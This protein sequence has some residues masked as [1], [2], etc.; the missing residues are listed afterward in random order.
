MKGLIRNRFFILTSAF[1]VSSQLMLSAEELDLHYQ[2]LPAFEIGHEAQLVLGEANVEQ[3][4][5]MLSSEDDIEES[6]DEVSAKAPPTYYRNQQK[7]IEQE[8]AILKKEE[9][10]SKGRV[11]PP[12][13]DNAMPCPQDVADAGY[14]VTFDNVPLKEYLNFLSKLTNSNFVYNE[15]DI[16]FNVSVIADS[17]TDLKDV[18]SALMQMLRVNGLSLMEQGNNVIISKDQG[19]RGIASVVSKELDNICT[20]NE[21]LITRVFQLKNINAS[22]VATIISSMVSS[23]ALVE[24]SDDTHHLVVTDVSTNI[25]KVADLLMSLD[26]PEATYEIGIFQVDQSDINNIVSLA[27]KILQPIAD[28]NQLVIV[29]QSSSNNVYIVSTPYLVEKTMEV[30]KSLDKGGHFDEYQQEGF[31]ANARF[32]IYKLQHHKGYQIQQTL[33]ELGADLSGAGSFDEQLVSTINSAQWL[34]ST[35]SLLF[36]GDPKSLRKIKDL[37]E[38]LDAP[39]RQVFIEVLALR[40]TMNNSLNLGVEYGYRARARN[41]LTAVGSLFTSPNP[42]A[43]GNA[44][45]PL[46]FSEGLDRVVGNN[47]PV[48]RTPNDLGFTSGVI[49]N[50]MFAGNNLFFD[51]AAL[52]NALQQDEDTE[53][54]TNPKLVTQ[55]TVPATFYVGSTRPFQTNSI[56]QASGSSSGNFVTASIEY[57]QLGMSLTVTPYLGNGDMITLEIEQKSSDFVGN[58]TSGDGGSGSSSFAIVPVTTDSSITTR[59]QIPDKH[60]LMISGM[61]ED[62]KTRSKSALPCLGGLPVVGDLLGT[63]ANTMQKDNL[64]VFM[65]PQIIDTVEA[66]DELTDREDEF[67]RKKNRKGSFM[68]NAVKLYGMQ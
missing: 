61:I 10:A 60:F 41:R 20:G 19:V 62:I 66:L 26:N 46:I 17:P 1:L 65:R 30:L 31:V 59:V 11:L 24:A 21:T 27:Q 4:P 44:R 16:D 39:L 25:S 38:M 55:D 6:L 53:V 12:V 47:I 34:Q 52:V 23:D 64:I 28:T 13:E 37:L 33:Q 3:E 54:I 9:K 63:M 32:L 51:L 5:L 48:P 67:Y 50:V 56:L 29:P 42:T 40:T 18:R 58:A 15:D 14:K 68:E 43:A 2:D 7:A 35:N 49:G 22:K 36:V 57:R 45:K 8:E